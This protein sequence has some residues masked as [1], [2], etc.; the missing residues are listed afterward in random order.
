MRDTRGGERCHGAGA[1]LCVRGHYRSE[2]GLN[3][4]W[5]QARDEAKRELDAATRE[6]AKLEGEVASGE[7]AAAAALLPRAEM[8]DEFRRVRQLPNGCWRRLADR[9]LAVAGPFDPAAAVVAAAP[10]NV[11]CVPLPPS[12]P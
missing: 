1:R 5:E 8:V 11:V 12:A 3:L 10:R 6:A 7:R 4:P 9:A 2:A